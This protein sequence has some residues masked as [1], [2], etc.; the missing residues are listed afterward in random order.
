MASTYINTI[1]FLV[2]FQYN[3]YLLKDIPIFTNLPNHLHLKDYKFLFDSARKGMSMVT[4]KVIDPKVLMADSAAAIHNGYTQS[5]NKTEIAM[6][7]FA[8]I[9]KNTNIKIKKIVSK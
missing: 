1:F 9:S 6:H 8:S 4:E 7:T 3:N 5:F 2:I